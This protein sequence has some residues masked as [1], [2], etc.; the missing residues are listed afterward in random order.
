MCCN[1]YLFS[2][3]FLIYES[4]DKVDFKDAAINIYPIFH[5]QFFFVLK[6]HLRLPTLAFLP[7]PS[8]GFIASVHVEALQS[9]GASER[10]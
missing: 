9:E 5:D 10:K 6:K 2:F 1:F 7:P 4:Y 3:L 8:C